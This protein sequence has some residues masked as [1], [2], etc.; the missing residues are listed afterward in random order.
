M[1]GPRTIC[2]LGLGEVGSILADDLLDHSDVQI[3]VWDRLLA[4]AESGPTRK[5]ESLVACGRVSD[6]REAAQA[7]RGCQV[8]ISAVTAGQSVAAAASLLP[9]LE[10]GSWFVDLNSVSPST[11]DAVRQLVTERGARY[12]EVAV[13]SPILPKRSSS[14]MLLSGPGASEFLS[15]GRALGFSGMSVLSDRPGQASASKMCRSVMIKG[16]EALLAE[17]LLAARHYG[18]EDAVLESLGNLFPGIEWR[19]KSRYMISRSLEH[20]ARRSEEMEEVAKTVD[21]AGVAPWMSEACVERQRWAAGFS[22]ALDTTGLN[23]MLDRIR[24]AARDLDGGNG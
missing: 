21:E 24:S 16:M 15:L 9:S 10:S 17:S 7:A 20:G 5:L 12:V 22:D 19:E 13:M 2:L 18:V 8:I 23:E 14:P 4:S 11:K 1:T 3:V 6:A